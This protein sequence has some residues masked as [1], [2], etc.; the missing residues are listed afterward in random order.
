MA[1]FDFNS[2]NSALTDPSKLET[3]VDFSGKSLKLDS[4]KD[5]Q[6]IIDAINACPDLQ[7]LTLT[8]NTLGVAA[9]QAIAKALERHPELKIARFS[10][11]FTGRMKTEIPPALV[12]QLGFA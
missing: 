3:G 11:M 6:P 2:I 7:Y 1:T 12:S 10:D 5:A 9:A 8:G 4:E